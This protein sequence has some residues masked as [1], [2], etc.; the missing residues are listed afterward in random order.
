MALLE[1]LT[2]P[3]VRLRE[4]SHPVDE[5][6]SSM[7]RFI[8]NLFETMYDA[9]GVGLASTQVGD[10]RSVCVMDC[11]DSKDSPLVMVNPQIIE[12]RDPEMMEEGCLS[13]PGFSEQVKRFKW[14]KVRALDRDGKPFEMEG[15]GLFAQCVQHEM[16]H[17]HGKLYID[18]LSRLKRERIRK[19]L[20]KEAR[21]RSK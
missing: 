17:L 5:I 13:V 6:D 18:Q 20:L 12:S 8:D 2:F 7:N 1:I 16:D 4:E 3:D 21:L 10:Q 19:R 14:I 9:P 15:D 11:S